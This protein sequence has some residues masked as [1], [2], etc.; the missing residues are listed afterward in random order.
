LLFSVSRNIGP[1]VPNQIMAIERRSWH[2][3]DAAPI[4]SHPMIRA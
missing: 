2:G 1:R 3:Q 4:E